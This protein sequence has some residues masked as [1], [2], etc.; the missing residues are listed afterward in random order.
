MHVLVTAGN[1]EVPIDRVRCITS[2]FSGRTGASLALQAF[3]RG[4][5]VTLLTSHPEVVAD[6]AAAA[7]L[8]VPVTEGEVPRWRC[9]K[10]RTFD[11]L[12]KLMEQR[13]AGTD[14]DAIIAS[15]AVSDFR[16]TGIFAPAAGTRFSNE[17]STWSADAG[18]PK[19]EDRAAGKVKSDE[20]ELWLRLGRAPKIIDRIRTDWG[21][22]GLLVKFKLEV[23]VSP[24]QLVETAERSRQHSAADLMVANLYDGSLSS[25]YVG[26]VTP[27]CQST[28]EPVGREVVGNYQRIARRELPVKLFDVL[29][30]A[31]SQRT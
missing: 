6:L 11:N 21:F 27:G 28:A 2:I 19:F 14:L 30:T 16:P 18:S 15:A 12:E 3:Q 13:I 22:R 9:L 25:F 4:H 1:T 10:F 5:H 7:Q 24:Q 23:G 17:T 26:P 8:P 31:F 29:E 20:P